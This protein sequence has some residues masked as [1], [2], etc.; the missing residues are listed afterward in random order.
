MF[1][2]LTGDI[3]ESTAACL[4]NTVNCEG[5]MGKGIAY[6]F[7]KRFPENNRDYVRACRA[8]KLYIGKIHTFYEDGKFIVNFPTKRS[9]R[10]KSKIEY[11]YVGLPELVKFLRSN[12]IDSCAIP[13]LGCGNGGLKW[14]EVKPIII[15][16][17]EPLKY[18]VEFQIYEPGIF[19]KTT[20]VKEPTKPTLSHVLLMMMKL[21]LKKKTKL[22][23]QK[24][25]YFYNLIS[26][27]DYFKFIKYKYGPYSHSID[28]ISKQIKEAQDYYKMN[29]EEYLVFCRRELLSKSVENSLNK[30][31][32]VVKKAAS[33]VN[34]LNDTYHVELAATICYLVN[35]SKLDENGIVELVHSWSERKKEFFSTTDVIKMI[36][37]L[38]KNGVLSK[39]LIGQYE[40]IL[41]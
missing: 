35:E 8:K 6:Q 25:A 12:H 3:L 1:T 39:N 38:E 14:A 28:V 33:L 11:L 40:V 15:K 23:L 5:Y 37:Y 29:T 36:E 24:T 22:N 19:R 41:K 30:N 26:N 32:S 31:E 9:W 13:P 2:Y 18:N 21:Q 10:E 7:K 4:V 20:L 34:I 16:Y 17:L 27:T